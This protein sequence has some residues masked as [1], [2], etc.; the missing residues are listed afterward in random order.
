MLPM[1][2]DSTAGIFAFNKEKITLLIRAVQFV[3]KGK[4]FFNFRL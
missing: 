1:C 4:I 3:F 2:S